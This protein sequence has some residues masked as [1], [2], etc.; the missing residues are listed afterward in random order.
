ATLLTR[1][2]FNEFFF[3]HFLHSLF[4]G[5]DRDLKIQR[6]RVLYRG[7]TEVLIRETLL[8]PLRQIAIKGRL[9][10]FQVESKTIPK[11]EMTFSN[12]PLSFR[13]DSTISHHLLE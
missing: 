4:S 6:Q 12:Q 10:A 11:K 5:K 7:L 2:D 8:S 9:N 3:T 13:T 1:Q